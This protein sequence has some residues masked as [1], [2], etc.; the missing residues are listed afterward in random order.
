M[1]YAGHPEFSVKSNDDTKLSVS[2]TETTVGKP[3]LDTYTFQI[4]GSVSSSLEMDASDLEVKA[5]IMAM[6][7]PKCPDEIRDDIG[8]RVAY[9]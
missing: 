6:F 8:R 3:K 5:A 1:L 4:N 7:A 9:Q 2:M